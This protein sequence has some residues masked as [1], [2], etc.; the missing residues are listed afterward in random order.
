[1][2]RDAFVDGFDLDIALEDES[3]ERDNAPTRRAIAALSIRCPVADAYYAV[4]ELSDAIRDVHDGTPGGKRRL[5]RLLGNGCDDYQRCIYY[6]LAG[7][8]VVAML[9]D[10]EWLEALLHARGRVAR[11]AGVARVRL[12][13]ALPAYVAAEPDG[14]VPEVSADFALGASWRCG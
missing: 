12:L 6:A 14:P 10:L 3:V 1:M 8:G 9:D 13:D 7:R 2:N 4:R 11:K 5:T